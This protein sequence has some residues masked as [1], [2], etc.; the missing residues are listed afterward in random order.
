[1]SGSS[2][3]AFLARSLALGVGAPSLA[4]MLA[5]CSG[6]DGEQSGD[7]PIE[8]R[9]AGSTTRYKGRIVVATV[10]NPPAEAQRALTAAYRKQQPG[11]DIVWE[12]KDYGPSS[13]YGTW[14]SSQLAGS[15]V[16]PDIVSGNHAPL[17]RRYVNLDEYREQVNPY[18]GRRWD[19]DYE[20]ALYRDLNVRGERT[21]IG[22]ESVHLYWYYNKEIFSQV[23]VEPPTN[24]NQLI[25]VCAKLKAAR[26]VPIATNF[27]YIVPEWFASM[28]FDQFHTGWVNS[29][30]AQPGDWNWDPELDDNFEY[31]VEDP[32][33]HAGYTFS[34]QRF[35]RGLKEKT[36]RF[37]TPAMVE[38]I[39][40]FSRVFPQYSTD[41]FFARTDQYTPFLQGTTAMMVDGSWSLPLLRKDLEAISPER[42]QQLGI[43][44]ASVKPIEWDVFEFPSMRG[45]L[46]QADVRPP[47]SMTGNYLGVVDKSPERTEMVMDFLMF[48]AS[49]PGYSAFL[50]GQSESAQAPPPRGPAMV[51]GVQYPKEIQDSFSKVQQKGVVG[52]SY[53][54][55][56]VN[57]A[58]GTSRQDL[59]NLFVSALQRRIDPQ[60]YAT[61]LQKYVQ[62]NYP[63]LLRQANLTDADVENPSRRPR[64]I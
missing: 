35:Y 33:L 51:D 1:M 36:L 57:G 49:K 53:G 46:V 43:A 64:E 44:E 19:D 32:R 58:G 41:D 25:A 5:A 29:V 26:Q 15:K 62:V 11:V 27:D 9:P 4:T 22:T 20:F 17:F 31:D 23:G 30:R 28:Y 34:P 7:Q 59:R 47:E 13:A 37:D 63:R 55:F 50:Q 56:W 21:V 52:P 6:D 42:L 16:R 54:G 12:T 8:A 24:W 3:R 18:T 45:P 14:L 38:L 40:N 60:E 10:Q 61:K 2:R 48:W 39:T